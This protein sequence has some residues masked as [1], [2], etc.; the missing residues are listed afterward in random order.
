MNK[1]AIMG[2]LTAG[3]LATGTVHA[4]LL[5]T[6]GAD[7][8]E[9][10]QGEVELNGSYTIDKAKSG[11][12]TAKCH[13]TDGDVTLTGGIVSGIDF[14]ASLP[15]TIASREKI[16]GGVSSRVDGLNDATVDVKVR[17]YDRD[18]LKL[19]I[20]PGLILPTGKTSEGLSDGKTGVATALLATVELDGGKILLHANGGYARHNYRDASVRRSSRS[21]I[22]SVSFAAEGDVA[23]G[24]RLAADAGMATNSDKESATPVAYILGGVTYALG[25]NLDVY[26]GFK[27]G[28]TRPED[29]MA[30]RCGVIVKY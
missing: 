12:I 3:V 22:V 10:G 6:D 5:A 18:G 1:V 26:A 28:L 7:P 25:T 24:L 2:V 16:A 4:G 23:E 11:G 17:F 20:K 30:A 19:A 8:V 21:D 29:D 13:S 27:A 15:Y 14:S 9:V